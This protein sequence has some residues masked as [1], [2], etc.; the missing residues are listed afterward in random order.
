M[1]N[2]ET[3]FMLQS[4]T[5]A[6]TMRLRGIKPAQHWPKVGKKSV[7]LANDDKD[8]GLY[9][10]ELDEPGQAYVTNERCKGN[11]NRRKRR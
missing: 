10:R 8:P 3:Q 7:F 1:K 2:A 4:R 6:P 5:T 9:C 11:G